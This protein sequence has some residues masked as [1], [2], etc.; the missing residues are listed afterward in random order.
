MR[1]NT[2]CIFMACSTS[3]LTV[4]K[5]WIYGT[6]YTQSFRRNLPYF[7]RMFF[8]LSYTDITKCTDIQRWTGTEI[9]MGEKCDFP[10]HCTYLIWSVIHAVYRSILKL[11]AK[12]RHTEVSVLCEALG[13]LMMIFM[14]QFQIFLLIQRLYVTQII[15]RCY[16]RVLTHSLP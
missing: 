1:A 13:S 4:T 2:V 8:R 9:I 10:V 7:R 6:Y 5:I 12:Q 11:T 3:S 14:K 16:I 15:I